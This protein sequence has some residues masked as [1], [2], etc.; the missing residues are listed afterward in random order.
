MVSTGPKIVVFFPLSFFFPLYFF[1]GPAPIICIGC[2]GLCRPLIP[3][4]YGTGQ[5]LAAIAMRN[6]SRK[7]WSLVTSFPLQSLHFFLFVKLNQEQLYVLIA[8]IIKEK[9]DC[10]K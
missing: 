9:K 7:Q 3:I 2:T 8:L 6:K 10:A 1:L 5:V 4:I